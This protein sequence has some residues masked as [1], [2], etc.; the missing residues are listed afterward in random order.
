VVLYTE[1]SRL[2]LPHEWDCHTLSKLRSEIKKKMVWGME[3]QI[4]SN[5]L[6]YLIHNRREP[7]KD[8]KPR[9]VPL[10]LRHYLTQVRV[11]SHRWAI[12]KLLFGEDQYALHAMHS[13]PREDR[14]C[15]MCHIA[16][17]SPHHVLL[18]CPADV[19][20]CALRNSFFALLATRFQLIIP[21]AAVL[22]DD[23]SAFMF[24]RSAIF[25]WHAIPWTAQF[26]FHVHSHWCRKGWKMPVPIIKDLLEAPDT[27]EGDL[28]MSDEDCSSGAEDTDMDN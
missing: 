6:L 2:P 15:R 21:T 1:R 9:R 16:V 18:Q 7:Q 19:L 5:P 26:V 13:I 23:A 8:D 24:L 25:H 11:S 28:S 17:E 27:D 22:T 20:M 3:E 4:C 14:L 10:K 12:T